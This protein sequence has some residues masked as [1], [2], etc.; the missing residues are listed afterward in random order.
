MIDETNY[1]LA[2]ASLNFESNIQFIYNIWFTN[3]EQ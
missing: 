2:E 1:R 3:L